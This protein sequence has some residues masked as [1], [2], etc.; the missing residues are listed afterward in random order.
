MSIWMPEIT[1]Q[2][3]LVNTKNKF[4]SIEDAFNLIKYNENDTVLIQTSIDNLSWEDLTLLEEALKTIG[5]IQ[6]KDLIKDRIVKR[7]NEIQNNNEWDV[8]EDTWKV[9]EEEKELVKDLL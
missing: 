4:R 1:F 7:K 6:N 3:E 8:S 9:V 2:K 5:T